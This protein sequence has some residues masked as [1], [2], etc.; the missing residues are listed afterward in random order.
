M[1]DRWNRLNLVHIVAAWWWSFRLC[2]LSYEEG[3]FSPHAVVP[4]LEE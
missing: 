1:V 3:K 4:S 2:P